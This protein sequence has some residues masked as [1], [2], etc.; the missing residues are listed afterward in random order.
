M[1]PGA[2]GSAPIRTH[3]SRV[4]APRT[5]LPAGYAP[6][7]GSAAPVDPGPPPE[8]DL[9]Y[10][11]RGGY[12]VADP[13]SGKEQ[14]FAAWQKAKTAFD[15]TQTTDTV[16]P[17]SF[18]SPGYAERE[19]RLNY[20]TD[21]TAAG[22]AAPALGPAAQV[23]AG[24]YEGDQ[25]ALL[26]SLRRQSTGQ[27][28]LA[29]LDTQRYLG[30]AMGDQLSFAASSSPGNEAL[31]ARNAAMNLGRLQGGAAGEGARARVGER[32]GATQALSGALGT[33]GGQDLA[34]AQGNQ[35][36]LNQYGLAGAQL[37]AGQ[38]QL[39]SQQLLELLRQE[40]AAAGQQ[41]QGGI[42]LE[43]N[44]TQRYGYKLGGPQSK[45]FW[46]YAAPVAAAVGAAALAV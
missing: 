33:F 19:G 3:D 4:P 7:P 31:A 5:G 22:N 35:G 17:A 14:A 23:G 6:P 20:L 28:S 24:A 12:F 1:A 43:R 2:P 38:R 44:R 10:D 45:S 11:G 26:D 25:R 41:Q 21:K 40:Q 34:R 27:D 15:S 39:D 8:R 29:D 30:R 18:Q 32:L 37:Q 16:N 36:A 46:D 42:E 9:V 13:N